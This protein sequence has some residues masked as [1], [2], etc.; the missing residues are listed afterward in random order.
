[1]ASVSIQWYGIQLTLTH[2]EANKLETGLDA[3][4]AFGG[5]ADVIAA[6]IGADTLDA[7]LTVLDAWLAVERWV[8]AAVDQGYGVNLTL[9]WPAIWFL[10]FWLIIPTPVSPP[11]LNMTKLDIVGANPTNVDAISWDAAS[12]WR[13]WAPIASPPP[14]LIVG[15]P[16]IVSRRPTHLNVFVTAADGQVWST[17]WDAT[18][19]APSGWG[20][21]APIPGSVGKAF[22]GNVAAVGP[23]VDR[24]DL[25]AVGRDSHVST[26]TW[27]GTGWTPWT[28]IA[29]STSPPMR[30]STPVTA[31]ARAS[32]I[33]DAFVIA[34]DGRVWNANWNA[35]AGW[36][37]LV[38]G[39]ATFPLG[40]SVQAVSRDS[41]H[42][43]VLAV[44]G[45][46]VVW[47]IFF[48]SSAATAPWSS[49][50]KVAAP[51]TPPNL[52]GLT[53]A[54]RRPTI[55]D[56]VAIDSSGGL[57]ATTMDASTDSL[58]SPWSGIY[59]HV[60][61]LLNPTLV[62]M[63]PDRLSLFAL[64]EDPAS[65]TSQCWATHWDTSFGWNS[66]GRLGTATVTNQ[67]A[68]IG[69]RPG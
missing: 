14:P 15:V 61:S 60:G 64:Y 58:W 10:Q 25:F 56:V 27:D 16:T 6:A 54:S 36:T 41:T 17:W 29:P 9:P 66:W 11:D 7:I 65:L 24:L 35:T 45:T 46:G 1:M 13:D 69:R 37:W 30:P 19:P 53:I 68:A 67:V 4:T 42:I 23:T 18:G 55:V 33:L 5:S 57:W 26:T 2:D 59:G 50:S 40:W 20:G 34:S 63:G 3:A 21:W 31:V 48:D 44:D 12:G 52:N 32:D 49:W 47:H 43:D 62:A 51:S 28:A 22:G 38:L 39:T 8:I